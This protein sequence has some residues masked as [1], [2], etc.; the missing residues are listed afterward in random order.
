MCVEWSSNEQ[1]ILCRRVLILGQNWEKISEGIVEHDADNCKEEWERIN[2]KNKSINF[3]QTSPTTMKFW[4]PMEVSKLQNSINTYILDKN[5]DI[6]ITS[7]NSLWNEISSHVGRSSIQCYLKWKRSSN[8]RI[9]KGTWTYS[10]KE[11]LEKA[12]EK[13]GNQWKKIS[14][15]IPGRT[16]SQIEIYF[17]ENRRNFLKNNL[18]YS[19]DIIDVLDRL[20]ST[21]SYHTSK[22]KI[23]WTK[24]SKDNFPNIKPIQLRKAW[25]RHNTIGFKRNAWTS[26][27]IDMLLNAVKSVQESCIS[28]QIWKA[29]ANLV[30]GR[31]P[32]SCK[33]KY[34]YL[35]FQKLASVPCKNWTTSENLKLIE[36]A[37][38]RKFRWVDVA[39]DLRHPE[40]L[41]RA[42]FHSL[43]TERGTISGDLAREAWSNRE[44]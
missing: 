36:I 14:E 10:E 4:T 35:K 24:L 31:T 9:L 20:I 23:S 33:T 25:I 44:K 37:F 11:I 34:R 21:G 41:C 32:E 39:K 16:S 42:K 28:Y 7:S 1:Y 17:R 40:T 38:Q 2:S 18:Q 6:P 22:G 12:H 26:Q 29:V 8:Q 3:Y 19:P 15:L 13:Y 5:L 43:L 30:P 27:E